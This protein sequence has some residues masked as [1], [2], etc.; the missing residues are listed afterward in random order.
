MGPP[1]EEIS[2]HELSHKL[3]RGQC[4]LLLDCREQ[5]EQ[6]LACIPGATLLPMSE[7]FDRQAELAGYQEHCIVVYCHHGVRSQQ[8]A[9]WLREQGF[10]EVQSLSGGIDAW[11]IDIEPSMTRY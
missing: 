7:L 8:V 6:D 3:A 2:C 1:P 11:A 5:Q 10:T 9:A 4:I